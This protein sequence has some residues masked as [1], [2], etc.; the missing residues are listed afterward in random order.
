MFEKTN[1]TDT[2]LNMADEYGKILD[3]IIAQKEKCDNDNDGG[4]IFDGGSKEG[5]SQSPDVTDDG[6]YRVV[7]N[8][9]EMF[10]TLD[11]LKTNAQKGLNYDHVKNEYDILRAQPG[12]RELLNDARESGLSA[13]AYLSQQKIRD[14]RSRVEELMSRGIDEKTALYVTDLEDRLENERL[15]TERK[16]PFYEFVKRYPDVDPAEI[17]AEVWQKFHEG[18]DLIAAYALC[19]NERLRNEAKMQRQNDESRMRSV[20]SASG[21]VPDY[22][23]DAF[24][25]GLLG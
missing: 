9:K 23:P 7:Y 14:K 20:G 5:E 13:D 24:L 15:S 1:Q 22:V 11:E 25:E 18:M 19:E 12:A 2:T 10:L 16:K 6:R 17:S 4:D 3:E 8:G 21:T